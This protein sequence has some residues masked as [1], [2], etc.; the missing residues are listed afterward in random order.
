MGISVNLWSN[1]VGEIKQFLDSY[2]QKNI[3]MDEDVGHWINVYDKPLDAVDIISVIMDNKERY[4]IS[5]C[6]QVET[7][8]VHQVTFENHNDIIKGIFDLYYMETYESV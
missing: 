7:C 8:D 2:Y 1:K 3:K 6:I 4:D 5:L